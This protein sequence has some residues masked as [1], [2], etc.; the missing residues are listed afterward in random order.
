MPFTYDEQ[1][2]NSGLTYD[3]YRRQVKQALTLSPADETAIKMRPYLESGNAV[4]DQYANCTVSDELKATLQEAPATT[5]LVITEGWCGDAAF[6]L[7]TMAA[8]EQAVPGKIKLGLFLRDSNLELIDAN[9]TDGGRSIPKLVVLGAD[10]K[11]L[12]TW[13]PRPAGLQLQTKVW[14]SE[15]LGLQELIPKVHGWYNSDNTVTLQQEL[16]ELI[17]S[18]S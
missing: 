16:V 9:L 5:W 3:A 7:P 14:K 2:I 11:V 4:M 12:G 6:N 8:L 17:R 15:G 10:M 18:Y 1:F 13:G